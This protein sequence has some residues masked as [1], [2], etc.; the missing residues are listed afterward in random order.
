MDL[1]QVERGGGGVSVRLT[2]GQAR[3]SR[4]MVPLADSTT[5][6]ATELVEG[7]P[8]GNMVQAGHVRVPSQYVWMCL[9]SVHEV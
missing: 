4:C 3:F 5:I 1:E 9:W 8:V 7:G 6:K 2:L